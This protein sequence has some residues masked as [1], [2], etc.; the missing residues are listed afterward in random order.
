[1]AKTKATKDVKVA[2]SNDSK[3]IT[4]GGLNRF[5]T[6]FWD[7][8]KRR[9]DGTFKSARLTESDSTDK[10]LIFTKTDDT[11]AE[12]DLRDY[13]RLQDKNEFKQ[14]VSADNVAILSNR[15]IGTSVGS[16][17]RDRSLGFRQLTTNSFSDRYID[18]I[19]VYVSDTDNTS[20]SSTWF[21]WAIK[22]GANGK[23]GDTVAK[24][25][26]NNQ[27][28][29]VDTVNENS[30]EKRF[31][32]IPVNQSFEDDVYFIVRCATHKLE[33]V[34]DINDKY[35]KDVVNMNS[36]QPP[37]TQ[38]ELINWG[39]GIN[40]DGNTALMY[41]FGRESIGTL[42]LKLNKL[43]SD[44]DLYVKQEETTNTG[45]TAEKANKVVRL[46]D[47]G[48]LDKDMLPS[49]AI[50]EYF[51]IEQFTHE[52]LDAIKDRFE[53]GDV[54]VVTGEGVNKGKRFLC[55]NKQNNLGNLVDG[56]VELNSKDGIVKS[57]N[58]KIGEVNLELEATADK[59]KLKIRSGSDTTS[60][61]E[62]SVPIV[63]DGDIDSIIAGLTD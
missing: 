60:I 3:L 62:T 24:V 42:S 43:N 13:V 12:V 27:T 4:Q 63:T 50:N 11:E 44:S 14:D 40:A 30:V 9:Y 38:D 33:V 58:G 61:A 34:S 32:K 17:S 10:K 19:R 5:A 55:V 2:A 29:T 48:K 35:K 39:A 20:T 47:N 1:M 46:G 36:G 8:I 37:M 31:V 23:E 49:I 28:F 57:V 18:H 51:E 53:N 7:K 16:D 45:G 54:V 15:H 22:K 59:L 21:V 6:K 25:I 41:L 56:F 26:C 52:K